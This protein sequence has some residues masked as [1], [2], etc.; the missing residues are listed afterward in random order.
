MISWTSN[1]RAEARPKLRPK[2]V[3]I[4]ENTV[5]DVPGKLEIL[6]RKIRNGEWGRVSDVV[7]GVRYGRKVDTFHYGTSEAETALAMVELMKNEIL[8]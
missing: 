4:D 3:R 8:P 6:A 5:Y 1:T 7:V 2:V